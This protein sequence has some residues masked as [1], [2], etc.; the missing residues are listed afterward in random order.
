MLGA[1]QTHAGTEYLEMKKAPNGAHPIQVS[2]AWFAADT[3][4]KW[5][6]DNPNKEIVTITANTFSDNAYTGILGFWITTKPRSVVKTDFI[7]ADKK[8]DEEAVK[9]LNEWKDKNPDKEVVSE[10]VATESNSNGNFVTYTVKGFYVTY[11]VKK[12]N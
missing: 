2:G 7:V 1:Y 9:I 8:S 3:L 12:S 11:K 6:K 10:S 4:T 5:E